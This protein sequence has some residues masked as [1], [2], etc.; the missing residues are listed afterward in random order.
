[1]P[2]IVLALLVITVPLTLTV[3]VVALVAVLR[4]RPERTAAADVVLKHTTNVIGVVLAA[5]RFP[6]RLGRRPRS[7]GDDVGDD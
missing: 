5:F 3:A 7:R 2:N 4:P 6:W 1:M